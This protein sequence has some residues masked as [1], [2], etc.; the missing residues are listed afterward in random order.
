M[1]NITASVIFQADTNPVIYVCELIYIS[2]QYSY[3]W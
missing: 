1:H 2:L 3:I